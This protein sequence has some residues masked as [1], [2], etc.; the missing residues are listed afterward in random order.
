M[1]GEHPRATST[2]RRVESFQ[3]LAAR[4]SRILGAADESTFDV[5]VETC[6][7]QLGRFAEVDVAFATLVDD[8][9]C[10]SDDWHWIRDGLDA[11]A[12]PIGSPLRDTFASAIEFLRLG[13]TVA[14]EDLLEIELSG[15]ERAQATAN[16]LRAIVMV[17]VLVDSQLLGLVGLQVFDRSHAWGPS[18]LGQIEAVGQLV[19][20]GVT[21]NRQRGAL[22]V[23]NV[24][25]RR[26]AEYIP[27]GLILLTTRGVVSWVS[28][29][30]V[31]MVGIDADQIVDSLVDSL[32]HG[33]DHPEL[34]DHLMAAL[35]DHEVLTSA[36]MRGPRGDW[37][38]TDLALR[39]ASEPGSGVP[40]EIVMTVRDNH[41]RHLR[42]TQ[43][44]RRSD[45]DFL[46]GLLNRAALDRAIEEL[47]LRDGDVVVAFCDVDDFKSINDT[48][49]H[50]GGDDSLV[51]VAA[52][53]RRAVRADDLV[54]RVGGDEF[55]V[56]VVG[57][58]EGDEA[59][60]LG[61]RLIA[62]I[63]AISSLGVDVTLSGRGWRFQ[64]HVTAGSLDAASLD[65]QFARSRARSP[66]RGDRDGRADPL[67]TNTASLAAQTTTYAAAINACV[68]APN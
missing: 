3:S 16:G 12:P 33:S 8:E 43:L 10:V 48:Y 14:V 32:F 6:L 4:L 57:D 42:E 19:L 37:R 56:V 52:A 63:R 41:E 58:V 2:D 64:T 50:Q 1:A 68:A 20:H 11:S 51:A 61:E 44:E 60:P 53:L 28:P 47:A 55:V 38:W 15:S 30:L 25:A 59:R 45:L 5:A 35:R 18:I 36:R 22:A 54:A 39:L 23:A 26:I 62:A 31:R 7:E 13:H 24:R 17:P 29:S 65:A 27:D 34:H 40:D 21:R 46:T 66:G 9:E 67:P 49:G